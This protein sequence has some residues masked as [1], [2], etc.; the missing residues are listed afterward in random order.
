LTFW[1]IGGFCE[2]MRKLGSYLIILLILTAYGR[3]VA[4]QFGMLHTTTASCC[5][6][7]CDEISHCGVSEVNSDATEGDHSENSE[8]QEDSDGQDQ[9]KPPSQP[10]PCQLC[11]ILSSDSML[12]G[13]QLEIPS[14]IIL[15]IT[16]LSSSSTF[17]TSPAAFLGIRLCFKTP[18]LPL[19]DHPDTPA[20]QRSRLQRIVA[21]TTPVRGPSIA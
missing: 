6:V 9:P 12:M 4:D 8:H 13:D 3:C 7:S 21:K 14:P 15:D 17:C 5:Q 2:E 10:A 1:N 20:E 11:L 19:S 18:D 16:S